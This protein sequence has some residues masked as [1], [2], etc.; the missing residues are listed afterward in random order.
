MNNYIEKL[1]SISIQNKYF[2]WYRRIIERAVARAR[3]KKEAK[4]L[5]GYCEGHHILPRGFRTGGS[6]DLANIVYLT[7][8]EHILVHRLLCKF[9][10]GNNLKSSL[11]AYHCMCFKTNGGQNQRSPTLFQ[12][13]VART[14]AKIGNSGPR[15]INGPPTWSDCNTLAEFRLKLSQ[16]V[17]QNMSDPMIANR[18]NVSITAVFNWRR[19]LNISNRRNCLRDK[20]WLYQKYA[21]E[22]L[23]SSEIAA[24]IGCTGTAVQQYLNRYSIPIRSGSERQNLRHKKIIG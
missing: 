24:I 21:V 16:M 19:K 9:S 10:T 17:D 6:S 18:F 1:G 8:K 12:L 5:L 3:T 11:R 14:A 7:S 23:S 15:G 20:D 22:Q 2:N 4:S 13:S